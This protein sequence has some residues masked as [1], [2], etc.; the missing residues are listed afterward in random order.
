[1]YVCL[2]VFVSSCV[3]GGRPCDGR[4]PVQGVLPTVYKRHS[5]T[6]KTEG[7]ESHP[8]IYH[9]RREVSLLFNFVI[10]VLGKFSPVTIHSVSCVGLLF[11]VLL[12]YIPRLTLKTAASLGHNVL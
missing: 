4:F 10:C 3:G 1:M 5:A 12:S 11:A 9:T 7:L 2:L 6:R 8:P